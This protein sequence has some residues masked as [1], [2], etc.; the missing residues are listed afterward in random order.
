MPHIDTLVRHLEARGLQVEYV[1]GW[2]TRGSSSFHPKG[3]MDH[4]TAG[5]KGSET[6]PSLNVVTYGRPGLPGPLCNVYLDRRGVAVVVAAGR[7]NHAGYGS[8]KG[9][10]GNT[11]F[12]GIEAEAAN[13]SDWTDEMRDSYPLVNAALLDA[14]NEDDA[15]WCVGHSEYALPRGRKIDINGYTMDD[16]RE[17]TQ[18]VLCGG[19]VTPKPAPKPDAKPKPKPKVKK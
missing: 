6:R 11:Y 8:W 4:W 16:M 1:P 15:S 12:F 13:A 18:T 17:Q 10:T 9:R 2:S 3:V 14:I 7:A 5:P 19:K